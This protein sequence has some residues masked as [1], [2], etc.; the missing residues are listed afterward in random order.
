MVGGNPTMNCR[1][2][3]NSRRPLADK[4][5][6]A[7][8]KG[9]DQM[10]EVPPV[11]VF[12]PEDERRPPADDVQEADNQPAPPLNHEGSNWYQNNFSVSN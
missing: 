11:D 9:R 1:R 7:K 2:C 12:E 10:K 4:A 8:V 5:P 3:F 6:G